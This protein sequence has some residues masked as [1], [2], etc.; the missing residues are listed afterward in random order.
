[1]DSDDGNEENV[2]CGNQR[3]RSLSQQ[4]RVETSVNDMLESMY[5][6]Q[7]EKFRQRWNFDVVHG[8]QPGPW[9]WESLSE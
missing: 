3:K 8:P 5:A 4:Q 2:P 6:A 1:M 7:R 9:M